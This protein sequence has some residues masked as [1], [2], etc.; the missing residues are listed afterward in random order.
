MKSYSAA[1][2][3]DPVPS[4]ADGHSQMM[5]VGTSPKPTGHIYFASDGRYIKIGFASNVKNRVASLQT[6]HHK[7]LAVLRV[8][9]GTMEDEAKFHERFATLRARGEWFRR[10]GELAEYVGIEPITFHKDVRL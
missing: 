1:I 10:E 7:K 3:G 5:R 6:G 2:V 4:L 8:E 9:K